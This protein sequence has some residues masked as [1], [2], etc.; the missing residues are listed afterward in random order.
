MPAVAENYIFQNQLLLSS[1]TLVER[2]SDY[3]TAISHVS[4]TFYYEAEAIR[5]TKS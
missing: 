4:K 2:A 3:E 1:R 5:F